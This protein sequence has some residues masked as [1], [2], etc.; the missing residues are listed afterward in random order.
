MIMLRMMGGLPCN[1]DECMLES[2][3]VE[4][5]NAAYTGIARP[6]APLHSE[7]CMALVS[8]GSVSAPSATPSESAALLRTLAS[9]ARTQHEP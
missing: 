1:A 9:D 8:H 3:V 2:R 7:E 6:S 4:D 5:A